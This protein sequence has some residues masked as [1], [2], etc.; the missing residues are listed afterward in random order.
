VCDV[1]SVGDDSTVLVS[2]LE[3]SGSEYLN[4]NGWPLPWG[5]ELVSILVALDSSEHQV[6]TWNS[7]VRTLC[8]W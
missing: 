1:P 7:R 6:P 5:R 4:D 3:R 2:D 8:S